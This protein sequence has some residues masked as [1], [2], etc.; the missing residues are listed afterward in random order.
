MQQARGSADL[1]VIGL[2]SD[3]SVRR[4]KGNSRPINPQME[5]AELLAS[6]EVVDLVVIFE[7][8][9]AAAFLRQLQPDFWWKGSDYTLETLHADE[10]AALTPATSIRFASLVS[11]RSTTGTL[12]RLSQ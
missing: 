8:T 6:F 2:N 3:A 1:L 10:K 5:R 4:L 9:N 12:V 11:D 7:H